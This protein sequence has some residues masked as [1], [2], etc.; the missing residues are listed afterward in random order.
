MDDGRPDLRI[1]PRLVEILGVSTETVGRMGLPKLMGLMHRKGLRTTFT[2]RDPG[3]GE[4]PGLEL[5][6]AA[7]PAPASA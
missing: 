2:L 5:V 6:L 3:P 4:R 1:D 7:G